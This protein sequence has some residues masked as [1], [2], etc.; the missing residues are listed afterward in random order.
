[1]INIELVRLLFI[2]YKRLIV[3]GYKWELILS[4]LIT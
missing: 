2:V 3:S 4:V 1:M